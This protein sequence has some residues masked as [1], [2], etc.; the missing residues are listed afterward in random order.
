MTSDTTLKFS[1]I[2]TSLDTP[3]LRVMQLDVPQR[4]RSVQWAALKC[5]LITLLLHVKV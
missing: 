2:V 1:N 3:D 5:K 4:N